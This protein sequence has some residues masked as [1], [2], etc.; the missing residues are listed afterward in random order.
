LASRISSTSARS[1][2]GIGQA[3]ADKVLRKADC[4]QVQDFELLKPYLADTVV[5]LNQEINQ[6]GIILAEGTQGFGLSLDYGAFP[7]TTSR[8]TSAS[9]LAASLGL[10]LHCCFVDVIGVVRTYP[11]RV[12]GNSG[13]FEDDSTELNWAEVALRANCPI[14]I[15]ERTSVTKK[16]RRVATFSEAQLK[17]A[18]L[19]NQPTEISLTFADYLD[20][21]I[22][23]QTCLS[24]TVESFIDQSEKITQTEVTL[25]KTG[26]KTVIDLEHY[27]RSMFRRIAA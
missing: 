13:P 16:V 25:V 6:E 19:V 7:Y 11:I 8:D 4:L 12:A 14:D 5:L 10:S 17:K 3:T 27:R 22:H 20:W 18:C 23:E 26:P 15:T 24:P 1:R 21:S 9:A 2:E